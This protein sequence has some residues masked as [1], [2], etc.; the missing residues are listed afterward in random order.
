MESQSW[1]GRRSLFFEFNIETYAVTFYGVFD[2]VQQLTDGFFRIFLSAFLEQ[3]MPAFVRLGVKPGVDVPPSPPGEPPP[4]MAKR[5]AGI[6]AFMRT[7]D[8]YDLDREALRGFRQPVYFALGGLS[9]PD[10]YAEIGKRLGAV[11]VDYTVEL[12]EK[13]HHFDPPHRIEPDRLARS[14]KARWQRAEQPKLAGP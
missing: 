1:S 7:F 9:N 13:R 2:F 14:L 5:L 8:T 12:F 4:W 11:F 3:F 10:Q 6:S